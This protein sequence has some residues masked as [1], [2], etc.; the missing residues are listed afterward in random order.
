MKKMADLFVGLVH[1]PIYN[2]RMQVIATAVTNFD[3]HDIART[4]RT[5]DVKKYFLIHP[6]NAQKEIIQKIIGYWQHGFGRVYN[7]DRS[8][9]LDRVAYVADIAAAIDE[10][11]KMTGTEPIT[12]TTDARVYPNTIS[13]RKARSML[14]NGDRPLLVLFGTGFGMEKETMAAFD[15]ILEPVYGPSNYNHLCVRSAVAIILD[16]LAGEAWWQK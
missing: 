11:R 10:V 12:V 1:Y 8:E 4:A 15:Y 2:K 13:Y 14:Q 6:H 5:Y 7:P 9:A 3:I 16:R